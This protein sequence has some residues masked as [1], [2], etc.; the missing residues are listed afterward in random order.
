MDA[1]FKFILEGYGESVILRKAQEECCELAVALSHYCLDR[2][3]CAEAAAIELADVM[4]HAI[5]VEKLLKRDHGIDI[6][7]IMRKKM[8]QIMK[9]IIDDT[10]IEFKK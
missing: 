7:P 2:K 6:M 3:D 4:V 10:K 5:L 8:D 9:N 1:D